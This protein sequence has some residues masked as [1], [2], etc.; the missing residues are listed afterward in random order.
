MK[1]QGAT[2]ARIT[3]QASAEKRH[4]LNR[5]QPLFGYLL[6]VCLLILPSSALHAITKDK[7][8]EF[9]K[10]FDGQTLSGKGDI[11]NLVYGV[12][13]PADVMQVEKAREK[14]GRD[15]FDGFS[16][17]AMK[18]RQ[19]EILEANGKPV[20][21]KLRMEVKD[22]YDKL[23]TDGVM[24]RLST[25][26]LKLIQKHLQEG[27]DIDFD[28]FEQAIEW[29][30]NGELRMG[31]GQREMDQ[32][33]QWF[34]WK[35]FAIQAINRDV[36]KASWQRILKSLE[37]GLEIY[38]QVYPARPTKD[39]GI[40]EIYD[41]CAQRFDAKKQ[42]TDAQKE[43]LRKQVMALNTAAVIAREEGILKQ[44]TKEDAPSLSSDT[45]SFPSGREVSFVQL[46][47]IPISGGYFVEVT[48]AVSD[49]GGPVKD[50]NV[51]LTAGIVGT[52][53]DGSFFHTDMLLNNN[54]NGTYSASFVAIGTPSTGLV[55]EALD[56]PSLA[57]DAAVFR[58]SP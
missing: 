56:E 19:V 45:A 44:V 48:V 40:L 37:I 22:A 33:G 28:S 16:S 38:R 11:V 34:I 32:F 57:A 1:L 29:F 54:Y 7:A 24:Q 30:A 18:A 41:G 14:C 36:D 42:L 4:Q 15:I 27:G 49:P 39:T 6:A 52:E 53:V 55:F 43:A 17:A 20:P 3:A 50:S 8:K 13:N 2:V 51:A 58:A 5:R 23:Q 35:T 31:A 21:D 46:D 12:P 10:D 9:W 26:Q 47:M 25:L